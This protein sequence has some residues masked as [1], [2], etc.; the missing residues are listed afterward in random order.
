MRKEARKSLNVNVEDING[1]HGGDFVKPLAFNSDRGIEIMPN[2]MLKNGQ[3]LRHFGTE[4]ETECN[5]ISNSRVLAE[6]LHKVVFPN[7]KFGKTMFKVEEDGSLGGETSAEII[8]QPMTKGRIR[9]DY[10]SYQAMFRYFHDLGIVADSEETN[11]G[12]H[13]NVSNAV[14]G[15]TEEEQDEAIRKLYYIINRYFRFMCKLFKRPSNKTYWCGEMTEDHLNH[16]EGYWWSGDNA[17]NFDWHNARNMNVRRDPPSSHHN[18]VNLSHIGDGRIEI[19]LVGGQPDYYAYRN[20]ME[21]VFFLTEKVTKIKWDDL[22]DLTKIF[23]GCNQYVV[24]R[25]RECLGFDGFT[26]E[27]LDKINAT[28]VDEDLELAR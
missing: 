10:K 14:F 28:S 21:C 20:T 15:D 25:L 5:T 8:S 2:G 13:V 4:M 24:K 12:M 27:M 23:K 1:Y 7:F 16:V 6:V 17:R 18:C 26:H 11:C 22:E 3:P 9:N 19:R